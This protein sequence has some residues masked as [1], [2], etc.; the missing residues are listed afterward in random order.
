MRSVF[1]LTTVP[2]LSRHPKKWAP[3][4]TAVVALIFAAQLLP[5]QT[6]PQPSG[7]LRLQSFLYDADGIQPRQQRFSYAVSGSLALSWDKFRLPLSFIFSDRHQPY[8][9]AFNRFGIAPEWAWGK[10]Q[11]GYGNLQFSPFT[12]AGVTFLGGGFDINPGKLRLGAMAGRLNRAVREDSLATGRQ[13]TPSFA[14]MGYA[15][16]LGVGNPKNFFDLVFFKAK[17]DEN[18]LSGYNGLRLQ[19]KENMALGAISRFLFAEKWALELDA[20]ASAYTRDLRAEETSVDELD[21]L[22]SFFPARLSTTLLTAGQAAFGYQT[23]DLG[24]KL[25]YRR[26]EPGYQTMGAYF[27]QTDVENLT[28]NTRFNAWQRKL[29]FLGSLGLQRDNLLDQRYATSHRLIGSLRISAQP[30]QKYGVDFAWFNYG[31]QQQRPPGAV[32]DTLLFSQ[33]NRSFLLSNRLTFLK[34]ATL[35]NFVL[36]ANFQQVSFEQ[37]SAFDPRS[38][39]IFSGNL[40]YFLSWLASG[41]GLSANLNLLRSEQEALAASSWAGL[42]LGLNKNFPKTGISTG[43]SASLTRGFE[44]EEKRADTWMFTAFG[45]AKLAKRHSLFVNL[46]YLKNDSPALFNGL[47]GFSEFRG[48]AGVNLILSGKKT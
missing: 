11:L 5:A 25:Q 39:L 10:A 46:S 4:I 16:K 48:N 36:T 38:T 6:S 37:G 31:I 26:V 29:R 27:F 7:Y 12:L 47:P 42:T 35:Q 28:L 9:Q 32:S 1:Y 41:W 13:Q 19:P 20:A 21:F 45:S 44:A 40:N 3:A 24:L 8:R 23:R 15:V 22:K 43:C 14:R 33:V 2:A 30:S 34:T 18:S 17:D